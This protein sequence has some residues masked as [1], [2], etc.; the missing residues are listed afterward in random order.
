MKRRIVIT[1]MAAITPVGMSVASMFESLL[2]GRSGVGPIMRFNARR[3]PTQFAAQVLDFDLRDFIA[4]AGRWRYS[5]VNSHFAAAAAQKSS[6]WP[7]SAAG[8]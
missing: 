4:D 7:S 6:T 8:A 2:A 5:G 3:F 1:G